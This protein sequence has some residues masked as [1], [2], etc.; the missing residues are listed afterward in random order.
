MN[1]G[2]KSA[3]L[4]RVAGKTRG[5]ELVGLD[6]A[7]S[8]F[9]FQAWVRPSRQ[10]LE[11]DQGDGRVED[12]GPASRWAWARA[13]EAGQ[14]RMD[15]REPMEGRIRIPRPFRGWFLGDLVHS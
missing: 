7:L 10:E 14:A 13:R 11:L 2:R 5:A 1:S 4:G 9:S 12:P 15:A 8:L 6:A 3:Q